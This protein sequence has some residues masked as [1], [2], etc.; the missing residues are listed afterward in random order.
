MK[1]LIVPIILIS[2][3][4]INACNTRTETLKPMV[5]G[6][7]GEVIVV[8]QGNL[9][10]SAL[11]DSLKKVLTA[12]QPGLPQAEP[13]FDLI[14]VTPDQFTKIYYTH[15]NIILFKIGNEVKENKIVVQKDRWSTPQIVLTFQAKNSSECIK[16]LETNGPTIVNRI[17]KAE[18]ERVLINYKR[19]QEINVVSQLKTKYHIS[20]IIPKGYSLDVDSTNF[21]WLANE[22]PLTSQGIFIYFYPYTGPDN[23]KPEN[24]I[25]K[26]DQ[27]LKKYVSGP[28]KNT[29][30]A[31][32]KMITPEFK[33]FT[34]DKRYTAEL[35][36]LWKLENGYMGGPFVSFSTVDEKR[37]RVI[38]VEGFV[39]APHD[40]KRELLRQVESI[41]GTLTIE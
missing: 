30:M 13:I 24:L 25:R 26:R 2:T 9:W 18:Q 28:V 16:L 7:A 15:R 17:N 23:F 5:S 31:T 14:H 38:T 3:L 37:G 1:K 12:E 4:V 27:F 20:L 36:G 11:G 10:E 22:T 21:V 8:L 39:Y 41:A 33:A 6:R 40:K 19:Y 34:K 29:Y 32:E 35:R